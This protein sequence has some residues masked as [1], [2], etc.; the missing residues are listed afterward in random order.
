M[1]SSPSPVIVWF[2]NDLRLHDHAALT[3]AA[4]S[5]ARS[6]A[7]V[8]PVYVLDAEAPGAWPPGGAARWWLHHSLAALD[9]ALHARDSRLVLR[10]GATAKIM[11]EL[12]AETG[13]RELHTGIPVEPWARDLSA[14]VA[15][16]LPEVDV[17][18]HRTATLFDLDDIR[19]Q[20]GGIYGVYTPFSRACRARPPADPLPLPP[21]FATPRAPKSDK[22]AE[23]GLLPTRPDW[24][25]GLRETW[26]PGEDGA[27]ARLKHFLPH[28][29]GYDDNRNLP[30]KDAG[31]SML[32]PHLHWG[33]I[34]PV[35]VWHAATGGKAGAG[36]ETF[37]NEVIWRE[38]A[39][40]LLWHNAHLPDRPLRA[41][42][43][44]MPWRR[45]ARALRAWQRGQTG[46]PIVDAGMRQLWHTGWMHNRVRMITGSYLVKHMLLPWQDG[47]AWFWDTLCDADLGSNAASWQW[48]AGCGTDAAPYFRVFNPV[49]QG[50]KFDPDGAYVRRFVPEL[51][52]LDTKHIHAP[53]E[54]PEMLLRA[55]G[56]ELGKTYPTP[57]V[58]LA[59]GRDRALAAFRSLSRDAA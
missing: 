32:S 44:R 34:S 16:A 31:T 41:D 46:I 13:A 50:R 29:A 39:Q 38:F 1:S 53:W 22:L 25:S 51:E 5:A 47:E 23:W 26:T 43:A 58:D 10:R 45:D 18:A 52:K 4:K 59:E 49:L 54:A 57:I 56:I 3:A 40:Y 7:P 6:G 8:L 20:A 21:R 14:R 33:E 30:A 19:T 9:A 37:L 48:V 35:Q 2:R 28:L 27:Q 55:A 36:R 12:A 17:H 42:F 24:A 11:A 15:K